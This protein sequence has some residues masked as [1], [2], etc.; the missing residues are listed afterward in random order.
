MNFSPADHLSPACCCGVRTRLFRSFG[1]WFLVCLF[2]TLGPTWWL[3]DG[4][5]ASLLSG[6]VTKM[7]SQLNRD[8]QHHLSCKVKCVVFIL[9]SNGTL[10]VIK[11]I[12]QWFIWPSMWQRR[13]SV[14]TQHEC[15]WGAAWNSGALK[16]DIT[17]WMT[18]CYSVQKCSGDLEMLDRLNP[19]R[20]RGYLSTMVCVRRVKIS[21]DIST[22]SWRLGR[23]FR[24]WMFL[25]LFLKVSQAYTIII[26]KVK[27]HHTS[28]KIFCFCLFLTLGTKPRTLYT[29]SK[30]V[31]RRLGDSL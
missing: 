11:K 12:H 17:L 7:E 6:I 22:H 29:I 15:W 16:I 3:K 23:W 10:P 13:N 19:V 30:H 28:W 5:S 4:H 1:L 14:F 2:M 8:D 18:N 31:D 9:G 24:K 27:C 26:L 25:A 20:E 21:C